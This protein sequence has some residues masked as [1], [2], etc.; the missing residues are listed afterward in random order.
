MFFFFKQK[1]AYEIMPSLVGSEMCIRDRS[2]YCRSFVTQYQNN[3]F[4]NGKCLIEAYPNNFFVVQNP[5]RA[6]LERD[7]LDDVYQ[8]PY[9]GSYHPIYEKDGGIP[10]IREVKFSIVSNRGCFGG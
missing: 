7:E 3:D 5:P 1:T 4:I 9:E 10:A 6:P 2:S 8:L